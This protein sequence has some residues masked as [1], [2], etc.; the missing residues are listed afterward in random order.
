MT[1]QDRSRRSLCALIMCVSAV[2]APALADAG[3]SRLGGTIDASGG[4]GSMVTDIAQDPVNDVYLMV[5]GQNGDNRRIYGRFV[6]GDGTVLRGAVFYISSGYA[7]QPRVAYSAALGGFLTVWVDLAGR[8]WG[9]FVRYSPGGE[10]SFATGEFV[11]ATPVGGAASDTPPAA[12]CAGI[13]AE[14]LVAWRQVGI[15]RTPTEHDIHAVRISL[16]GRRVGDG[17]VLTNDPVW[18]T[19]PAVG[20]DPATGIYL[21]A[22]THFTSSTQLWVNRIEAE[23]GARLGT[24]LLADQPFIYRPEFALNTRTGEFLVSFYELQRFITYGRFMK[25]DGTITSPLKPFVTGYTGRDSNDVAY[26]A[27]SNSFFAVVHGRGQEV[28]GYEIFSDGTPSRDFHIT[29]IRGPEGT[30]YP[31]IAGH[32][33]RSEWMM[34]ASAYF[35]FTAGQRVTTDTQGPGTPPDPPP[36]GDSEPIDLSPAGAPNGSWFLA[37]GV[38][39]DRQANPNGMITFYLMVNEHPEPVNVRAYFSS[40]TGKTFS[41]TFTVPANSRVSPNLSEVAGLG[42]FGAVFQSLTPG[43][44]IFVERSIYWGPNLE[45]STGEVATRSLALEWNFGEGSRDYFSNYYLLFNPH[46]VA[47]SA[48][49]TFFLETGGTVEHVLP[50]GPQQRVTLDASAL[51]GLAGQNFGVKISSTVPIVAERAMYFGY[52]PATSFIGGTASIGAPGLSPSWLFAEGAAGS[53]FHTFYLL[54]NPNP[55]PITVNRWFF[56]EDGTKFEGSYTVDA[57][58]RKT[59]Y[60]N[61]ELGEIGGAAAQFSSASPFI[62]ERSTYWGGAGGWVEG[63]NVIGS[64]TAAAEWHLPEGTEGGDFDTFLLLF[65]PGT[66]ATTADIILYVQGVGRLTAPA[67]LRPVIGPQTRVTINMR[68]FLSQMEGPGGFAPDTLTDKSFSTTVRST[69]GVGLVVEHALYRTLD[70]ENRWRTGSV[71]FGVPR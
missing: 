37:E 10:P 19:D 12:A 70:G 13:K 16:E 25:S 15:E 65:N 45:G 23:S 56:R 31:R 17:Y 1:L 46:Q 67:H 7:M 34:T 61:E 60:L 35:T 55:F 27:N 47:G 68:D 43:L 62:A 38:S 53:G 41:R 28:V 24:T 71:S 33:A 29:D 69:N 44:D 8:V 2:L 21:L 4:I 20:Y 6:H 32:S 39:H 54:M 48:T 64:P 52:N 50:F 58:S 26:N 57:G 11:I 36:T 5:S 49:F 59:V 63:T 30:Y 66:D 22:H 9:R 40:E 42:T 18:Q 14:C 3:P 51:P